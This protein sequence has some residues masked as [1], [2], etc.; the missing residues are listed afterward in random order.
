MVMRRCDFKSFTPASLALVRE[1]RNVPPSSASNQA[2]LRSFKM[3]EFGWPPG[4]RSVLDAKSWAWSMNSRCL[5]LEEEVDLVEQWCQD[6]V[7]ER[8]A[9]VITLQHDRA[10]LCL[11]TIER[12]SSDSWDFFVCDHGLIVQPHCHHAPEE[13]D[14]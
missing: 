14:I 10:I 1:K 11:M 8:N 3:G 7:A 12:S 13:G 4:G 2:P 9:T 6:N 5:R